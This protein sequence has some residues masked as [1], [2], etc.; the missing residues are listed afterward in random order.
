MCCLAIWFT[1]MRSSAISSGS[2]CRVLIIGA[3][4]VF[5]SRLAERLA[6][7]PGFALVLAGRRREPLEQLSARLPAPSE[8]RLLDRDGIGPV[9][10][11][12]VDIVVDAAGPFQASHSRVIDAA[13]AARID[14]ID[15]ADSR[16]FVA[17]IGRHDRAARQAGVTVTTGASS[18]P[19]LSHAAVEQL[20]AGWQGIDAIKVGI[21]PGNRAPRGRS[22]VAAILSYVG[23]PVR[24]FIDGA[25]RNVPGWGMTHRE[26][27][28]GIGLRWASVCDTPDQDL[29]VMR[30]RPARSAQFFAGMELPVLHLGLALLAAPVRWG[31]IQSLVGW[32]D[33][34][35]WIARQLL[36]FGSDK[37][38]MIVEAE[39]TDGA[40][41]PASACWSLAADTNRGP[42]VP[43]L[44]TLAMLR[45][46]RDDRGVEHGARPCVGTLSLADF[47]ADF[48]SLQ[49]KT[50]L[51]R[52]KNSSQTR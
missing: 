6:L 50:A 19:A 25:W 3:S 10:L 17:G 9:D 51:I 31:W 15:L 12:G 34:L 49:I 27:I 26:H 16:A 8:I 46:L 18:T 47:E 41:S 39:G 42:Y 37:G 33:P 5:G 48:A 21:F 38:A 44:A 45:R 24:V 32:A 40:G 13:I 22:V 28:A 36:R 4:G 23:K 52:R 11:A 1:S 2:P 35:L 43:V 7:E 30:F 20:V 14:Y 29:L